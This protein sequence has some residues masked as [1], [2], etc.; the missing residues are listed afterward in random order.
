[1]RLGLDRAAVLCGAVVATVAV[2]GCGRSDSVATQAERTGPAR[3]PSATVARLGGPSTP[4]GQVST[5]RAS[6]SRPVI[7]QW[8]IPLGGKRKREMAMYS[9]RHYGEDTFRLSRPKVIVEH[10]TD[11]PTALAAYNTF[12]PDVPDSEFNELP[13]TCAHFLVEPTGRIDQLVPLTFRCRH[14]VGL[15]WTAIGIE[16]VGL[17]DQEILE[18]PAQIASSLRL[19]AWLRC[20]YGIPLNDVIGHSESLSSP[21]H[22]ELVPLFQHQTHFD[23]TRA[24]MERFRGRL[25]RYPCSS[26][27]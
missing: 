27:G 8:P 14:T 24:D 2:V 17:S 26:G 7:H 18:R 1:M 20:L 22:R 4:T 16:N 11:T 23:W 21:Y 10:Y 3:T 19:T 25:S 5:T 9:A 13:N 6:W 15:N 12:A